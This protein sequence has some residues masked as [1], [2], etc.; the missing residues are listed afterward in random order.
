MK[1]DYSARGVV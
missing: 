1:K